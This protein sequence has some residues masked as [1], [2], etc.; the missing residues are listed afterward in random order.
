MGDR[1]CITGLWG[2][3][4]VAVMTSPKADGPTSRRGHQGPLRVV[5]H[6]ADALID[7]EYFASLGVSFDLGVGVDGSSGSA[8]S[9]GSGGPSDA[10]ATRAKPWRLPSKSVT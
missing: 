2:G 1:G 9:G 4:Y 5:E 6:V 7:V 10:S 8:Q 3:A